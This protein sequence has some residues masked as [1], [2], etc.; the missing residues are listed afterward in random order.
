MAL[1]KITEQEL[2]QNGVVS[3]PDRLTGT[4]AENKAVF[5]KLIRN[6]VAPDFNALIDALAGT[7]GAG[8][9]GT[10]A[11]KTVQL[12]LDET[13]RFGSQ[14]VRFL[15][16]NADRVLE[17]SADGTTWQATGSSG[18]VVLDKNGAALPQRSRM[19]FDNCEVSD[20]GGV[21]VVH[22]IKGDKGEQGNTGATGPQ[23][24]QGERGPRGAAIVPGVDVDGIMTFREQDTVELPQP[25]N[26]RGPQGPAGVQGA[27]GVPG[28]QGP[29]GIQGPVGLQGPQG[30]TGGKGDTGERGPQGPT[31]ET[32]PQGIQG[33]TGAQ[34][35]QG[36]TGPQGPQGL[37]GIQGAQGETGPAGARGPAGASG[38]QGPQGPQGETGAPGTDGRS[39]TL[40]D[41]YPTLA[42][43][44]T[45][46]PDGNEYAYQVTAEGG[47]IFIWSE[48][49]GDWES[50]GKLQGPQGAQGPQGNQGSVGPQG[51]PGPTGPQ[52]PQGIQGATG[53]QGVQGPKGDTGETGL[54]GPQGPTGPRGE[55]GPQGVQ[56]LKGDTGA[57]G[58][59][60]PAGVQGPR[61]AQGEQGV[62]GPA[63]ADGKSAYQT[64]VEAGFGGTE[65]AFNGALA[66]TPGHIAARNNPHGVTAAQV[67]ASPVGHTHDP[68]SVGG[69]PIVTTYTPEGGVD[70]VDY[71]ADVPG[72]TEY[73]IGLKVSIVPHIQSN[74]VTPKF[75]IGGLERKNIARQYADGTYSSAAFKR[76]DW[77]EINFP[78]TLEYVGP[79]WSV[80]GAVK[81]KADDL[82]GVPADSYL[83]GK[84][85]DSAQYKT[86]EQVR[87]HIG[88]PK[89]YSY[90]VTIPTSS[91]TTATVGWYKDITVSGVTAAMNP[92]AGLVQSSDAAAAKLQ[93]E[94]WGCVSRMTTAA[95]SVR[96]YCYE[97]LPQTQITVRLE[98][99][100]A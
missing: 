31:G 83:V 75:Q 35:V 45:A 15:R 34:G 49:A 41:I 1:K 81:V 27:Q 28:A 56:G 30:E 42:A 91:W 90:S 58:P 19:Q 52:G 95:N 53:P 69:I 21:T 62:Q 44:K 89:R 78:I 98:G 2:S 80:V 67:G 85:T 20:A 24:V 38:A 86:P 48:T 47:A 40:Q 94:A 18:H 57:A 70:G 71:A 5:D 54:T 84:D 32:G 68:V 9:L 93:L 43:L 87:Q 82:S 88:A 29:Q 50:L 25:V 13:V 72:V 73:Y 79:G 97:E 59:Q 22:G 26:V 36:P 65:T 4:A 77:L 76:V 60:G 3:A 61:G 64:A 100:V 63:G 92:T 99:T 55:Q 7:G 46:F 17:T 33:K 39:F 16:V 6:T 12:E 10:A 23:G 37:Q 11:G 66:E 14:A 51:E 74:N 96:V 8:E